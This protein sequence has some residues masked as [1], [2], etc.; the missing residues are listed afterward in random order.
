MGACGDM[1]VLTVGPGC[2]FRCRCPPGTAG[3]DVA[4]LLHS[5]SLRLQVNLLL[6]V[7]FAVLDSFESLKI[8]FSHKIVHMCLH[9][10]MLE[11][12]D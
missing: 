12:L 11:H 1:L 8:V 3:K 10:P 9:G 4:L 2:R 6:T 7:F 5:A